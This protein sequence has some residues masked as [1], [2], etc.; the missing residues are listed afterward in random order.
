MT[1]IR[2][3]IKSTFSAMSCMTLPHKKFAYFP[4]NFSVA[5]MLVKIYTRAETKK[6]ENHKRKDESDFFSR[7][8]IKAK[9]LSCHPVNEY[10]V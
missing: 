9:I 7:A 6:A 3:W 1:S 10:Y 4:D 5:C 8:S 2:L